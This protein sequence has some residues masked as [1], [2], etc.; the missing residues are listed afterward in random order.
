MLSLLTTQPWPTAAPLPQRPGEGERQCR[1][2]SPSVEKAAPR[3]IL[4]CRWLCGI[5]TCAVAESRRSSSTLTWPLPSWTSLDSTHLP[6]WTASLSSNFWTWKSQVTGVSIFF[7]SA[8]TKHTGSQSQ[9]AAEGG[10]SQIAFSPRVTH[11]LLSISWLFVCSMWGRRS[12]GLREARGVPLNKLLAQPRLERRPAAN[13]KYYC[14]ACRFRTNKKAKIW[15]DT[16]L[17]ER[18]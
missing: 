8:S 10:G 1:P 2:M 14:F 5:T 17:V 18:G 12:H 4:H 6:M 7:P 3:A 11:V 16:F 13:C 9:P 15:R